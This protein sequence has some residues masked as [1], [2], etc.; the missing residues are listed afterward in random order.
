M[1]FIGITLI[2]FIIS[3]IAVAASLSAFFIW[4]GTKFSGIQNA[5]FGKAFVA[6]LSSSAAVWVLTGFARAYFGFGYIAGWFLG[7]AITLVI[8]RSVYAVDWGKA[9]LIW[10]FTWI[11]QVIVI[12]ILAILLITGILIP[13]FKDLR[14][15]EIVP[16]ITI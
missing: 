2:L 15:H 3:C 11:A 12:V 8:L 16:G 5:T 6:A 10:I 13:L 1:Q 4:L 9:F 7:L 14:F